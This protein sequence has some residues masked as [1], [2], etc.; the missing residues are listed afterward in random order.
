MGKIK[1]IIFL[2]MTIFII[3]I[4]VNAKE[5][6]LSCNYY[7]AYDQLSGN[8]E[9]TIKCDIYS[10]YSHM[11]YMT[12]P[13]Q[14]ETDDKEKIINWEKTVKKVDFKAKDYVK[15]YNKCPDYLVVLANGGVFGNYELHA[16]DTNETATTLQTNLGGKRFTA[17][18]KELEYSE[19]EKKQAEENIANSIQKIKEEIDNYDLSECKN[20]DK[21]ITRISECKSTIEALKNRIGSEEKNVSNYISRNVLSENDEIVKQFRE[22]INNAQK[23]IKNEQTVLDEEDKKIKEELEIGDKPSSGPNDGNWDPES[24]CGKDNENCNIDITKF[25]TDPYVARTLKFIGLLLVLAK[26]LIP[27]L[28]IGLGFVD[29]AKIV[30]SGKMDTAKKQAVN[31]VKRVIIGVAIFLI[32]TILITIYNVAYSIATDSEVV[33]DGNLH[34]PKNFKNCVGCILDATN[35]NACI[36]NN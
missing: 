1:Y 11:C 26:I 12:V 19:N 35:E 2:I 3:P 22:E 5:I 13:S 34:V 14:N 10:D 16:A 31:I 15:N 18:N 9:V 36:I 21:V 27:A 8:P 24:L 29:L 25:C 7:H 17:R 33:T 20:S 23:F 30:I 4:D 6:K 32:P 28:I